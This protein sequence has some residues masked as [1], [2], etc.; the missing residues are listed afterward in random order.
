MEFRGLGMLVPLEFRGSFGPAIFASRPANGICGLKF[1]GLA[2][3]ALA[4]L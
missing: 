3:D 1:A 2:G 4:A